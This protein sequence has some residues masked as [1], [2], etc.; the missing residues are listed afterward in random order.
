MWHQIGSDYPQ[1]GQMWDFLR[2]ISVHFGS[3]SQN[4]LKLILKSPTFV[5]FWANLTK[6]DANIDIAALYRRAII[7]NYTGLSDWAHITPNR[8]QM[9]SSAV[10]SKI[11][12]QLTSELQLT[13]NYNLSHLVSMR[14][15]RI[16]H[17][18]LRKIAN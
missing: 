10:N 3:Q 9:V 16:P 15:N 17:L 14:L 11:G 8:K 2:S 18:T 7:A 4:V 1:M 13:D 12:Y 5:R 6:F